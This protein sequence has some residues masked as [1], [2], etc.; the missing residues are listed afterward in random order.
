MAVAAQQNGLGRVITIERESQWATRAQWLFEQSGLAGTI[1]L[2]QEDSLE[3]LPTLDPQEFQF[4]LAFFDSH[5]TTRGQEFQLLYDRGLLRNLVGFHDTSRLEQSV[6]VAG[7]PQLPYLEELDRIER[8]FCRGALECPYCAGRTHA[9]G[10]G[11]KS[12]VS[13]VALGA[14]RE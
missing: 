10:P 11:Y 2:V 6:V 12:R 8:E 1:M 13:A 3:F 9:T 14:A 4:D 5:I 7:E